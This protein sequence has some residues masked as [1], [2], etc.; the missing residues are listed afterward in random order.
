[1]NRTSADS[2]RTEREAFL[3][4]VAGRLGVSVDDLRKAFREAAEARGWKGDR[5]FRHGRLDKLETIYAPL[6]KVIRL[7]SVR[8][9]LSA[10]LGGL[11]LERL[12]LKEK[13]CYRLIVA[14][15]EE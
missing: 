10:Y 6:Y 13:V 1:M 14:R 4:D 7:T 12:Y 3:A 11:A 15:K 9:V 5:P 2:P 8:T